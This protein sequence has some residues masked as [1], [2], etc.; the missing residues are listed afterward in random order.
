M[1][2][3]QWLGSQG[4]ICQ[5]RACPETETMSQ[6]RSSYT[7]GQCCG[8]RRAVLVKLLNCTY[9]VLLW[10][11]LMWEMCVCVC[12]LQM[13]IV[14]VY[15]S[16]VQLLCNYYNLGWKSDRVWIS[17]HIDL[18]QKVVVLKSRPIE[19]TDLSPTVNFSSIE[20]FQAAWTSIEVINVQFQ[21]I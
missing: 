4:R 19:P 16:S 2:T 8:K 7:A 5:C 13:Y 18:T 20:K 14:H 11:N 6:P 21:L 9:T 15:W 10:P 17:Y 1:T 12:V 3:H